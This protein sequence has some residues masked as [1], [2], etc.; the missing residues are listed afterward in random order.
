MVTDCEQV[1]DD[2]I[3]YFL[4]LADVVNND[5]FCIIMASIPR[6]LSHYGL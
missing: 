5:A 2:L 6:L 3:Y 1:Y 4:S